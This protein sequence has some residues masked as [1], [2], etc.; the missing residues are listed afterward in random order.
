MKTQYSSDDLVTDMNIFSMNNH[1]LRIARLGMGMSV[2][3]NK[4]RATFQRQEH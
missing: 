3:F 4:K 2:T 1:C